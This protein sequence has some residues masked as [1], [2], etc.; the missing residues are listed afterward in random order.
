MADT[1]INGGDIVMTV[2]G[3]TIG[4]ATSHTLSISMSA[5]ETSNKTS[6]TYTT[7]ESGRLDVSASCEG[8]AVYGGFNTL[9]AKIVARTKVAIILKEGTKVYATGNFYITSAEVSA[10]NQD[11]TTFS[12]S[13]E[14]A[15][16]FA[17]GSF[18]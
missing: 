8:M 10:P 9:L 5:R 1:V 11:N 3:T 18:A 4:Y 7:R 16:T 6:G 14:L 17:L 2:D 12:L 15:D 13:F